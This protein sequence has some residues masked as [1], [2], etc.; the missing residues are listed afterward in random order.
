M[1][2]EAHTVGSDDWT[3]LPRSADSPTGPPAECE[4]GFL[5]ELH[6]FLAHYLTPGNPCTTPGT[7]GDVEPDHRY[8]GRLAGGR[9]STC[10]ASP[11][12][13]VEVAISYVTDPFAGGA[14]V[15]VDR[16]RVVI[17]GTVTEQEGFEDGARAV[18]DAGRTHGQPAQT[19]A[20][21]SARSPRSAP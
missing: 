5:L 7:T 2:V 15:F 8:V 19:P 18:V 6:P 16:T 14:G 20:T 13:Q 10:P 3:T 21:S 1:I 9:R 11:A 12:Q 4:V 17:G